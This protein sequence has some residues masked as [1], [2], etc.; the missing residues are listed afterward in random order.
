MIKAKTQLG[1]KKVKPTKCNKSICYERKLHYLGA[2]NKENKN[3]IDNNISK[4][5][6]NIGQKR[7]YLVQ[8]D[9]ERLTGFSNR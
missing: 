4:L 1:N 3:G 6:I 2:W 8:N 9:F 7:E 5:A